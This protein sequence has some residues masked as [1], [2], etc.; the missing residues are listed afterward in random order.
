M[1][2]D[3]DSRRR[4]KT[5]KMKKSKREEA[6]KQPNDNL[7]KIPSHKRYIS[8]ARRKRNI[9]EMKLA[10]E[11]S[12]IVPE[13][14]KTTTKCYMCIMCVCACTASLVYIS[15]NKSNEN[16]PSFHPPIYLH[17][18]NSIET[19]VF[20]VQNRIKTASTPHSFSTASL[21][22]HIAS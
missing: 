17:K 16:W 3:G 10:T 7:L 1:V 19:V 20:N 15:K 21:H 14:N 13:T 2:I 22:T 12:S 9:I 11:K 5:K 4:I 18:R 8:K 6:K